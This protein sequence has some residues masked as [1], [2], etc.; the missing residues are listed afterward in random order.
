MKD[1]ISF[2]RYI[3]E[4]KEASP[5]EWIV[6]EEEPGALL[7]LSRF[8]LAG[9]PFHNEEALIGWRLCSLRKKLNEE[10]FGAAFSPD[11]Q[12]RII[13]SQN[14]NKPNFH[15]RTGADGPTEDRVFL[16]SYDEA[17]KYFADDGVRRAFPT[18]YAAENGAWRGIDG[19]SWWWLRTNARPAGL[20]GLKT[21][22]LLSECICRVR[23]LGS[24][25]VDGIVCTASGGVRPAVRIKI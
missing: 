14:E 13:P 17:L 10:F 23:D 15:Y 5:I 20:R 2:G 22:S 18:P 3:R 1:I 11:E 7:L 16:L 6:L 25:S 21:D 19:C 9:M 12:R 4:G 8:V 24:I